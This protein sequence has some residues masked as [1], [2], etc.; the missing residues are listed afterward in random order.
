MS[1][2]R[3]HQTTA[4]QN[5]TPRRSS[6]IPVQ[7]P[8]VRQQLIHTMFLMWPCLRRR[9]ANYAFALWNLAMIAPALGVGAQCC[10][11]SDHQLGNALLVH[12]LVSIGSMSRPH[13]NN[14]ELFQ[15]CAVAGIAAISGAE[16]ALS[17]GCVNCLHPPS[18][19]KEKKHLFRTPTKTQNQSGK[20]PGRLCGRPSGHLT[21]VH[22]GTVQYIYIYIYV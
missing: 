8:K 13:R 14:A 11:T 1:G 21:K 6:N 2:I 17:R 5:N 4:R 16:R 12:E 18:R 9:F 7:H 10:A 3:I 20:R 19:N 22:V 15:Q